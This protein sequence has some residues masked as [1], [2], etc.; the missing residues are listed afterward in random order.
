MKKIY[1]LTLALVCACVANAAGVINIYAKKTA[2]FPTVNLYAWTSNGELLGGWPGTAFTESATVGGEEYWKM[3]V[4]TGSSASWNLIFNNGSKQTVD[5]KGPSSD[6][7]YELSSGGSKGMIATAVTGMNPNA[8]GI[9]LKGN[10]IN[11]WTTDT[12]YEFQKT[13]TENVYSLAGVTLCGFF[14]IGDADWSKINIGANENSALVNVG[15]ATTL[16]N[17]ESSKNL[18]LDGTYLCNVTL[19]M[20]NDAPV[21]TIA[22]E[23]TASGVY[24]KGEVNSWSEN[25]D[26]QFASLGAGVYELNKY[27][28]ATDGQF[29]MYANGNW[30]GLGGDSEPVT[31]NY[32]TTTLSDGYNMALPDGTVAE[33][34]TLTVSEDN[35]VSVTVVEATTN[36]DGIFLRGSF[37]KWAAD[38]AYQ[39]TETAVAGVYELKDVKL[40]GFFKIADALWK[41]V[42]VGTNDGSAIKVGTTNYLVNGGESQ[43]I[44]LDGTYQCSLITLDMTGDSPALTI[45]GEPTTSGFFIYGDMNAWGSGDNVSDYE[46]V[47]YG[48]GY[49][50]IEEVK[51]ASSEGAF[52]VY[53]NGE[54]LGLAGSGDSVELVYGDSYTLCDGVNITLPENTITTYIELFVD[55]NGE[56]SLMIEGTENSG[57]VD[58]VVD[59]NAAVEYFN[60]QGIKVA[61]PENG[62]FIK[63]HGNKVSKV[64]L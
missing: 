59:D 32:G 8:T 15:E 4:D 49:Y 58:T 50:T 64:I 9:Y 42:N 63:K 1:F 36:L 60:L 53:V 26:W 20:R 47:D 12:N 52:K 48:A 40:Q 44:C 17:N 51:I 35:V 13:D 11:S 6:S 3:S 30:Y 22:G 34:F 2:E 19:D 43:N 27:F 62:L 16:V 54:W 21:L 5:M 25:A 24:L 46:F 33:K 14:K 18:Y 55:A 56:A 29:K 57:I 61:T 7:Y 45:E 23:K 38:S 10:E 37:N 28:L 31:L 41:D 39:F